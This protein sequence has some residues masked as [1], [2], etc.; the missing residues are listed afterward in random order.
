ML[1]FAN[2][3]LVVFDMDGV[4]VRTDEVH[5]QAYSDLW[6]RLGLDGPEYSKIAGQTTEE[7][8]RMLTVDLRPSSEQ[9]TTWV[10]FKQER[11]RR[12]LSTH[13]IDYSDAIPTLEALSHRGL[14]LAIGTGASPVSTD[15]ILRRLGVRRL[16]TVVVTAE[17]VSN[18]KPDP[19]VYRAVLDRTGERPE[20]TLIVEDSEAGL[21]AALGSGSWAVSV[22]TG[23]RSVH[24]RFLGAFD[25]LASLLTP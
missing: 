21:E 11:A 24:P 7:A 6:K 22:R 18:G 16:F 20:D 5:G 13:D 25:N 2:F 1:D 10:D 12:Y 3:S 8:I 4:L 14:Q 23:L 17:D 9:L 19:E 15:M